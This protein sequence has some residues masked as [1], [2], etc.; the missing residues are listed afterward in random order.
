MKIAKIFLTSVVLILIVYFSF[1]SYVSSQM[2]ASS[3]NTWEAM[4]SSSFVCPEGL[5]E[6]TEDWSKLGTSRSCVKP[7]HGKWEAWDEGYKHIDGY[8]NN[9]KEH[10][11]WVFYNSDGSIY[12]KIEYNQGKEVNKN[13]SIKKVNK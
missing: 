1:M 5:K 12:K 13:T 3:I 4:K 11:V 2:S 10:G 9:E 7:K 6:K 8:Y